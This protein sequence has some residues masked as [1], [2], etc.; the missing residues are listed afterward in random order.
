M[1]S[2]IEAVRRTN[3]EAL[4]AT[5][6]EKIQ[7]SLKKHRPLDGVAIV[8]PGMED[9]NGRIYNYEEGTDMMIENGGNYKRWSGV[10]GYCR[11]TSSGFHLF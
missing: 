10:V 5:A 6:P 7:D 2:P 9:M 8:P 11:V 1:S 4:K 3:E